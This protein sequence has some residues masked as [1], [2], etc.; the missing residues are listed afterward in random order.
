[1]RYSWLC[2]YRCINHYS[3][4]SLFKLIT[5]LGAAKI[6]S[7]L[8]TDSRQQRLGRILKCIKSRVQILKLE[9]KLTADPA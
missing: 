2:Y 5:R 6:R 1:M 3:L 7:Q 8:K 9:L 4:I